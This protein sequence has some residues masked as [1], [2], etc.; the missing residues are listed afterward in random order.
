MSQQ[1]HVG[2]ISKGDTTNPLAF[3]IDNDAFPVLQNAYQWRGRIKRKRG[4]S[5]LGRLNRYIGATDGT[6][7]AT[8]TIAPTPII[9]GTSEFIVGSNLFVDPGTA[10]PTV[11]LMSSGPGTA[12][13]DRTTGVLTITGSNINTAVYYYTGLPVMGIEDLTLVNTQFPGT[14]AFD[15]HY[16]YNISTAYPYPIYDVTF[17]KN[18]PA[19]ASTLPGYVPKVNPTPFYWNGQDSQQ[20]WTTNYEYALWATNGVNSAVSGIG[21]QYKSVISVTVVSEGPPA[22]VTINI[23]AHGLVQ[24]DFIFINESVPNT[25]GINL[26]TGYVISPNPQ[27]AN[28]VEV[29]FPEAT[30]TAS[31]TGGIAQYLTNTAIP[32]LDPIRW[33]DGDPTGGNPPLPQTSGSFG[34]VNF[35]PPLS[36]LPFS[37]FELVSAQYYLV[38]AKIIFPF[39]DRLLFIGPVIQ[40]S[41][42]VGTQVYLQD[43]IIY[44]QNGTPY[45]NASFTG[46]VLSAATKFYPIL[47]ANDNTA[48]PNAYFEDVVGLGGNIPAATSQPI[49]TAARNEDVLILGFANKQARLVYTGD[50]I[51]PFNIFIINSELGSESTFSAVTLDR[52]VITI[53]SNGIIITSQISAQRVDLQIPDQVFEFV[54]LSQGVQRICSQRDFINEWI[55]FTYCSNQIDYVYPNQTLQYNYRDETWAVFNETYTTYG[56]FRPISGLTWSTVGNT[57]PTWG[58][59]NTP[60]SSGDSTLAQPKVLA[61]NQQGFIVFRDEGTGE[62]QSLLIN[63]IVGGVVTSTNHCL[64]NG[65]YIIIS[66]SVYQ[67]GNAT[68]NTFTTSPFI[69]AQPVGTLITRM[70]IPKILTRQF[71]VAWS[72]GRKTRIGMQQYLF[73]ATDDAQIE[74]QIYLSQNADSPYNFGPVLPAQNSVNDALIYTDILYTCPESTNLGLTPANTNLQTPTAAQQ[75]QIW[76]RMNTSLI[77]DTVQIGFTLSDAQMRDPTLT[78][79]FAEIELHAFNITVSPSQ[80]LV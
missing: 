17:Y 20:F 34:W 64:N 22:I 55:Y 61:G 79:Q 6:G 4:T 32:G 16:A 72:I 68:V 28:S 35:S 53:G 65:D 36:N 48:T 41:G 54:L 76:H 73:T 2:N 14:L 37:I 8:I 39:K 10:G 27:S 23:T 51:I 78:Y 70:Y 29:E 59:W 5:F 56:T 38:G 21:M 43:T 75:A 18:P 63:N 69:T 52:G 74:L 62:S 3:N 1:I 80:L 50:D 42:G 25:T 15:T 9:A 7:A 19:N 13:L 11:T 26:Q 60:W 58:D 67:V 77:G 31:S 71:P 24:G 45:Y 40:T 46:S 12:T 33:Y 57:Y 44:S 47:A 30:I 66:G 49:I